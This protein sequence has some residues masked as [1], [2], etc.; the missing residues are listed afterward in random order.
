MVFFKKKN[1]ELSLS[2]IEIPGDLLNS[3]VCMLSWRAQV[4]KGY[5]SDKMCLY[6]EILVKLFMDSE[7]FFK[8]SSGKVLGGDYTI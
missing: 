8:D 2:V 7:G 6:I 3:A 5:K 1:Q 4:I